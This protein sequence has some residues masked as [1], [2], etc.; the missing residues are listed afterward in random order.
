MSRDLAI[1]ITFLCTLT[2]PRGY[3]FNFSP[4]LN[5]LMWLLANSST[6]TDTFLLTASALPLIK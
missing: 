6:F 4:T 2:I 1:E 3:T 5:M